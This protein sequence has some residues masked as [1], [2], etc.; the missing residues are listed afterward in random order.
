MNKSVL[1]SAWL[2]A[3][4]GDICTFEYGKT[5]KSDDRVAEGQ[6]PVFGSNGVIDYHNQYFVEAPFIIVGRKGS[7]GKIT[8][9][10]DN[11]FPIDTTFYIK[12]DEKKI[13]TRFLYELLV[14]LKL[15]NIV[16]AAGVPGL[17][18]NIA[19]QEKVILPP[20][21]EQKAIAKTLQ[22]W[23]T[24]IEKTEALIAAKERQ[25]DWLCQQYFTPN[26]AIASSWEHHRI[27]DF[28][29][30]RKEKTIPSKNVPLYSLTIEDGV[31]EKTDR[32]NRE[33]L[34]KDKGNKTYKV[35]HPKDIVFNPANL[36]WGAIAR[37]EKS[38]KVAISPIYE[39]FEVLEGEID[40][41]FLTFALTCKRQIGV[42]ATKTEGT[43]IERMAV[44]ADIFELCEIIAPPSREEQ[45]R[46]A[47]TLNATKKEI[48][49]LKSLVGHYRTQKRSLMQ[50]LLTGKQKVKSND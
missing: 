28:V 16:V 49:L 34:V 9:S 44:K 37:S 45:K 8:L 43:L 31:T 13:C 35:V 3:S 29:K 27:G 1:P 25:F 39:V 30:Q 22:T 46:I 41:D 24:A 33:F 48:D 20:L 7:A 38:H 21:P 23:D 42:F 18:R 36:R 32:Y 12:C 5:L 10:M 15:E 26:S 40:G 50:T 17:N 2:Q 11:G 14:V 47:E 6:Y 4:L 19:Y